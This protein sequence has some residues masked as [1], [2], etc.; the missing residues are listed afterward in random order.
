MT[1]FNLEITPSSKMVSADDFATALEQAAAKIRE[2]GNDGLYKREQV[3]QIRDED[4][5]TVGEWA[6]TDGERTSAVLKQWQAAFD[7][8]R[9]DPLLKLD[10][11]RA[12]GLK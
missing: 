12:A 6:L 1:K 9:A 5:R 4:G 3:E 8:V 7:A 10:A 2:A 11:L